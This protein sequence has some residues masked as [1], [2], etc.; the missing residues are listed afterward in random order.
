[1]VREIYFLLLKEY[2]RSIV[3]KRI[4]LEVGE[5]PAQGLPFDKVTRIT[6]STNTV[7]I[8]RNYN[9]YSDSDDGTYLEIPY[10][11]VL[12]AMYKDVLKK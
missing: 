3:P 4:S 12:W 7:D 9:V 2:D 10:N 6:L 1:M 11:N 8:P 5:T